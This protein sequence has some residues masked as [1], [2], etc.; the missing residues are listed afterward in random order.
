MDREQLARECLKIE[1]S[2]GS[3][4]EYLAN[5]GCISPWG[6]WYRL[7]REELHR[8]SWQ[9]KDGKEGKDMGKITLEIKKKAVDVALQGG[10]PTTYLREQGVKNPSSTWYVIKKNLEKV[11]PITY[12]KV[13][14]AS[15]EEEEAIQA[16]PV[17]EGTAEPKIQLTIKPEEVSRIFN[18]VDE[19]AEKRKI[20]VEEVA[21]KSEDVRIT[22]PT[23]FDGFDITGLRTEYGEFHVSCNGYLFFGANDHDELEMPVDVWRKF[24]SD[25]PRIMDI[26]G[27]GA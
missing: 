12:A 25:L 22:K 23:N 20:K 8:Q 27:I 7:Q 1:K 6:T 21:L 26:L 13:L 18:A 9:I 17:T 4:R 16:A 2:G 24:A 15:K 14:A 11:D 10:H 5:C 19:A 3:V